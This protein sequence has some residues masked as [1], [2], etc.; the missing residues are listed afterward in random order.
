[1]DTLGPYPLNTIVTGD[2]AEVL[3][4]LPA[5][6]ID[7]TVTSPPYDGLRK[8]NGYVFDFEAIAGQLVRATKPGGVI[9]WVVADQTVDGSET[10]TSFRQ[11][12]FFMDLGMKLHDTM[13]F[14]PSGVGA[15]GSHYAYWQAFEYMFVFSKGQ[16]NTVNRIRD[17]ANTTAGDRRGSSRKYNAINSRI[18]HGYT[19]SELGVR[20]NVW[21]YKVGNTSGDDQT[22]HPA[23]FPEALARDHILSWSNAGD[24]VLDPF[25]GSGTTGKMA[26]ELGRPFLGIDISAEYAE[27][28]RKRIAATNPPLF[29]LP[30]QQLALPGD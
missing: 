4:Q 11:A 26:K 23:P 30:P 20:T 12:L 9:V 2:A 17:K 10:G 7:L 5:E 6:C 18:S 16:P 19:I 3:A 14:M 28:A 13:I 8:Y 1:M 21:V 29:T 27:I 15:K 22:D 25:M 24:V